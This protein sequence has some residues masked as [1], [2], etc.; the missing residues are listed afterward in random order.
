[1]KMKGFS[2]L[3]FLA[4]SSIFLAG[5]LLM[6]SNVDTEKDLLDR[7]IARTRPEEE[8]N[9]RLLILK[10]LLQDS[11]TGFSADPFLEHAPHFFPDLD[12]GIATRA[13]AF[14]IARP[15][16]SIV[17]FQLA[18]KTT[19]VCARPYPLQTGDI[20]ALAGVTNAGNFD[21]NYARVKQAFS[22]RTY[23]VEFELTRD[24]PVAGSL[25]NVQVDGFVFQNSSLYWVTG[26]GP[27]QPFFGPIDD[28]RYL[29]N[30]RQLTVF[31]RTGSIEAD[32]TATL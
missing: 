2:L 19:V 11:A 7:S 3:E 9:Y 27:L 13:D 20:L 1:M 21:W 17:S 14:S 32:I 29:W 5:L 15:L 22:D 24:P 4:G 18:T 16:A 8:S 6:Y 30:G 28:F 10:N 12:F 25:V 23:S 31:W 26:S